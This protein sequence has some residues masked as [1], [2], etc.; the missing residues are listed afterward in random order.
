[1]KERNFFLLSTA[2]QHHETQAYSPYKHLHPLYSPV[3]KLAIKIV[4]LF[5]KRYSH[6][7]PKFDNA[8][9]PNNYYLFINCLL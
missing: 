9:L 5:R 4:S 6:W 8:V 7:P 1:M 3:F 2:K